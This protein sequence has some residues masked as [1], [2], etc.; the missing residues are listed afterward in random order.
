MSI[1]C[2]DWRAW[3]D[4]STRP[5]PILHVTAECEPERGG[6]TVE[7]RRQEPADGALATPSVSAP[8]VH[9]RGGPPP[10]F[11]VT[12]GEMPY[13]AVEVAVRPELLDA[14]GSSPAPEEFYATWQDHPELLS[15]A[16]FRLPV[17]A[18]E[19]LRTAPRLYYRLW[20]NSEPRRWTQPVPTTADDRLDQ[21]PSIVLTNQSNAALDGRE[22]LLELV[23]G[24]SS[25]QPEDA[26]T[27]V[28]VHYREVT[29]GGYQ[30]VVILPDGIRL[31]IEDIY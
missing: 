5:D 25:A 2:R 15:G 3:Y 13:Y 17:A 8:P 23:V 16:V 24:T 1:R 19:R 30:Q 7:L 4:R 21:A 6:T 27:P 18:W 31:P 10:E 9:S 11:R 20:T 22:L 29:G 26:P 12:L 28:T 14:R